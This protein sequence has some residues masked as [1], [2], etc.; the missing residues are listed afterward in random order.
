MT[1]CNDLRAAARSV[2]EWAKPASAKGKYAPYLLIPVQVIDAL[3]DALALADAP[4][5]G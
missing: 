4:R 1:Q 2:V 5:D 3:R